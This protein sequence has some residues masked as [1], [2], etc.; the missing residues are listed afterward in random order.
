M[1]VIKGYTDGSA[2]GGKV[3]AVGILSRQVRWTEYSALSAQHSALSTRFFL[4][5]TEQHTVY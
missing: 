4:D 3:G 5:I 2:H 1:E